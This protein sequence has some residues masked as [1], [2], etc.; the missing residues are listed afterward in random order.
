[1][2][3]ASKPA[4]EREEKSYIRRSHLLTNSNLSLFSIKGCKI[5][6]CTIDSNNLVNLLIG[7]EPGEAEKLLLTLR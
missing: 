5:S 1:M 7:A 6:R 2:S 3:G 4:K